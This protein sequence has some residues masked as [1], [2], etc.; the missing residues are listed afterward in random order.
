MRQDG[1]STRSARPYQKR[2]AGIM[3]VELP[4]KDFQEVKEEDRKSLEGRVAEAEEKFWG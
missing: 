2:H 3:S 4:G 1:G